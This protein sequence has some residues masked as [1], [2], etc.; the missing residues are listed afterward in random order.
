MERREVLKSMSLALGYTLTPSALTGLLS[1]C[2]NQQMIGWEPK[3]FTSNEAYAVQ[4]LADILLPS[5]DIPGAKEVG[6][7]I[8]ADIF[9]ADAAND[10]DREKVKKG[11]TLWINA[12]ESKIDKAVGDADYDD[13]KG[14]MQD[15]FKID[16]MD[17]NRV[18]TLMRN[19]SP[20]D[21]DEEY[22]IYHFLFKFKD[23]LMLGFYASEQIGENVLTYLP[24]PGKFEG[25]IPLQDVGNAWSLGY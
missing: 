5:T 14:S 24:V 3:F 18:R 9:L 11:V 1:A 15:Y 20:N 19:T 21:D 6:A 25:C 7:H 10:G 2:S 12:F 16:E 17:Q 8:F 13:F 4:Q 22:W 23:L